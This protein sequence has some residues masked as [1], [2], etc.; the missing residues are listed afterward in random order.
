MGSLLVNELPELSEADMIVF[1]GDF[2]YRLDD[3][4]Y[5]EARDFISQRSCD[6]LR[7]KDQLYIEMKAG[8]VFQG[9]H[10]AVITF[11]PTYKFERHQLGLAGYDFGE[12]KRIPAW[13]NR[14]LYRDNRLDSSDTCSLN[15]P[16]VSSV[17][18]Y[19]ACMDVTDGDHKPVRC[20]FS[21]ELA[22][23][24]EP[25]RRKLFGEIMTSNNRLFE[26]TVRFRLNSV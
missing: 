23:V 21:V 13:C 7:E 19:E 6:W 20:I 17:L 10:E 5:D 15:C 4:S 2:N 14:V 12:K 16:V 26:T 24:D 18:Q 9:M 1:L 3:I 25:K 8:I 22:R 11:P